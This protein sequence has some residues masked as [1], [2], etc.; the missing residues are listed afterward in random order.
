MA[1][2]NYYLKRS[3]AQRQTSVVLQ[4]TYERQRA[5]YYTNINID[6]NLWVKRTQRLAGNDVWIEKI[7]RKLADIEGKAR[8]VFIDYQEE[9]NKA[10]EPKELVS[11]IRKRLHGVKPKRT[12][13]LSFFQQVIDQQMKRLA[14]EGKGYRESSVPSYVNTLNA[15]RDYSKDRKKKVDFNTI[16]MDFYYDF[17][18]YL[19]NAKG[20]SYNTRGLRIKA[21]R[22]VI[23]KAKAAGHEINVDL[24][25]FKG[26]SRQADTIAL[27]ETELDELAKLDLSGSQE[28][29]RDLFLIGA[30][31]GL[32]ISDWSKV[33]RDNIRGD[34]LHLQIKKG[35]RRSV[36]PLHPIVKHL[37]NKY[38]DNLPRYADQ[39]INR[40]LKD[41]GTILAKESEHKTLEDKA[42]KYAKITSHVARR[43]F[44]TNMYYRRVPVDTIRAVSQHSTESA[45]LSYIR[46]SPE[47]HA[48]NLQKFIENDVVPFKKAK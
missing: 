23:R 21:I 24:G 38:D 6:P 43:S 18:D 47:D 13:F 34:M 4:I 11:L 10:P 16:N 30:W 36:L 5:R 35:G 42:A 7:N 12:T 15:L 45:F 41:I 9:H 44:C 27:T 37:L 20:M 22:M 33:S 3:S 28:E 40:T 17:L 25:E 2:F 32:R 1:N 39:Y 19:Q 8:D 31:T 26:F 14:N 29:I 48:R 46:V